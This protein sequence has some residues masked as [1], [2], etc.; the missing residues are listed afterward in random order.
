[1]V[2]SCNKLVAT[3]CGLASLLEA[4]GREGAPGA[5]FVLGDGEIYAMGRPRM[6]IL[7]KS[8]TIRR[9]ASLR[10]QLAS[11]QCGIRAVATG[12]RDEGKPRH[13]R[14]PWTAGGRQR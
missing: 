12:R 7:T 10:D 6:H 4:Y 11:S 8:H 2:L 13:S 14:M 9:D 3:P 1:M 5:G